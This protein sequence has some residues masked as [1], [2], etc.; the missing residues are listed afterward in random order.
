MTGRRLVS[1]WAVLALVAAAG[2][3]PERGLAPGEPS[4]ARRVKASVVGY[5]LTDI[6]P[7]NATY[8]YATA[9]SDR[10]W[11]GGGAFDPVKG[12]YGWTRSSG[13]VYRMLTSIPGFPLV[14]VEA[15]NDYGE[16]A[17][18]VWAANGSSSRAMFWP[19][20]GAPLQI[21]VSGV[22]AF[23][24]LA[25]NNHG[26]VVGTAFATTPT[27]GPR[28][29]F[30]WD[31]HTQI[32]TDLGTM[33]GAA[34]DAVNINTGGDI[35][36]CVTL[37]NGLRRAYVKPLGQSEQLLVYNTTLDACAVGVTD[38]GTTMVYESNGSS[39]AGV[40][41][42]AGYHLVD[43]WTPAGEI[44]D[45]NRYA[46]SLTID[47]SFPGPSRPSVHYSQGGFLVLPPITSGY[48]AYAAELNAS[49]WVVGQAY[50]RGTR[51]YRAVLWLPY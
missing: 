47:L 37:A 31:R 7:P 45:V 39:R 8:A 48:P 2:C 26:F 24:A 12:S 35:A 46:T 38:Q 18:T 9:V 23:R 40:E 42:S 10:G 32:G 3:Q 13:G 30:V 50:H 22:F 20:A 29:G 1:R 5:T 21:Y 11:I 14:S 44:Y 19:A 34:S 51:D 33:G 41:W 36:G 16:V 17:G 15:I 4:Q 27:S 43:K 25:L 6:T 28:H 49:D